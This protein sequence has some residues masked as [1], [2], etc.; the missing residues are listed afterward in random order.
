MKTFLMAVLALGISL[1]SINA[2]AKNK[3]SGAIIG[4]VV[5][6]LILADETNGNALATFLGIIA[7]AAIGSEIGSLPAYDSNE[8][9]RNQRHCLEHGVP[10]Y[11]SS[12]KGNSYYGDFFIVRSGYYNS[13]QCRSYRSEIYSYGGK[14]E[15]RTGTT[16]YYPNGWREVNESVVIWN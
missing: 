5:G 6:G 9:S 2:E 11:S 1:Q 7:G 3:K 13:Y 16:C 10:G 14:R 8:Y 4:A 12:W 15:I